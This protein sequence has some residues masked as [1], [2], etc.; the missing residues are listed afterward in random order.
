MAGSSLSSHLAGRA[1]D[2][3]GP[4]SDVRRHGGAR[5][6]RGPITDRNTGQDD[7]PHAEQGALS[8]ARSAAEMGDRDVR[9]ISD[10]GI[11]ADASSVVEDDVRADLRTDLDQRASADDRPRAQADLWVQP[12]EG[13][14]DRDLLTYR[15][16]T[17]AGERRRSRH[18]SPHRG[19]ERSDPLIRPAVELESDRGPAARAG[20]DPGRPLSRQRLR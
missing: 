20:I 12:A 3:G 7:A 9:V 1:S 19:V 15:P 16:G 5:P 13:V 17:G 4:G 10:A 6:D 11:V 2:D 8:R 14:D 18:P